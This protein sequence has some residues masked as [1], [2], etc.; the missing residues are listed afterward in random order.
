MDPPAVFHLQR[1]HLW[2][3]SRGLPKLELEEC[4]LVTSPIFGPFGPQMNHQ[5]HRAWR[6]GCRVPAQCYTIVLPLR[7]PLSDS[8]REVRIC[9]FWA[10]HGKLQQWV[11]RWGLVQPG[12][13]LK[14]VDAKF[15]KCH[16]LPTLSKH[17]LSLY[18]CTAL[19]AEQNTA[20]GSSKHSRKRKTKSNLSRNCLWSFRERKL[21]LL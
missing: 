6:V 4:D 19:W 3:R 2:V 1:Y 5:T 17:Q 18:H 8:S 11:Q 7:G 12:Q 10:F 13:I 20:V 15:G 21:I 9:M 14:G 16:S